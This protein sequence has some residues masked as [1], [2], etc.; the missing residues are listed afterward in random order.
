MTTS[1]SPASRFASVTDAD[2]EE[3][4]RIASDRLAGLHVEKAEVWRRCQSTLETPRLDAGI[5]DLYNAEIERITR[6]LD[7]TQPC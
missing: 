7:A 2:V 3:F 1:R 5:L 6:L 4:R